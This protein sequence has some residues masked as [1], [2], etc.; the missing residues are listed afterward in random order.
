VKTASQLSVTEMSSRDK[1]PHRREVEALRR[2]ARE[3]LEEARGAFRRRH[4]D[5]SCLFSEQAVQLHLK[6][7]LLERIGDYPRTHHVRALLSEVLKEAY[8]EELE[9]F[10]HDN[11]ARLSS[12]EDAYLMAR[13]TT[14]AYT[15]EDAE[16]MVKLAEEAISTIEKT[17]GV[18]G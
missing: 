11:R 10:L 3:F 8:L 9:D 1:S 5:L 16:D 18:K 4:Y 17:L 14:K 2:S 12:L 15:K 6:S 7:I 13:Y